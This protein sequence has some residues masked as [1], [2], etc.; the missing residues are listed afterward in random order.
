MKK[1]LLFILLA[2][3]GITNADA[4][5]R[6]TAEEIERKTRH[7][8]GWEWGAAGR[9]NLIFYELDYMRVAN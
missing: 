9:A 2:L 5:R 7:Y 4:K 1:I 3:V 6:E 8:S